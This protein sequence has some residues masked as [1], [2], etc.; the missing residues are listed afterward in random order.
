MAY[1]PTSWVDRIS[2][3]PGQFSATGSVPGNI[4]LVLNDNPTQTGTQFTAAL[5]NK[6]EQALAQ[7]SSVTDT[8]PSSLSVGT[9]YLGNVNNVNAPTTPVY[10]AS[11]NATGVGMDQYGNLV[12]IN[13][14]QIQSGTYWAVLDKNGNP[15]WKVYLTGGTIDVQAYLRCYGGLYVPNGQS[16]FLC[17]GISSNYSWSGTVSSGGAVTLTHNLG[18]YPIVALSGSRGNLELTYQFTDTNNI[19]ISN[20]SSGSNSW[21]GTVYLY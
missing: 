1:S 20:Y 6:I 18:H 19:V 14:S 15:L 17:N 7:V 2:Q 21:T 8:L 10:L 9:V 5:M 4:I 16:T 13:P 3:N 11:P 12:P